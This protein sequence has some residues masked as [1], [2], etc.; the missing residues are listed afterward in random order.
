MPTRTTITSRSF[1]QCRTPGCTRPAR[2]NIAYLCGACRERMRDNGDA[3][4]TTIRRTELRPM[5]DRV[6]E[7][8]R[9]GHLPMICRGLQ[10]IN[11][12]LVRNSEGTLAM[13]DRGRAMNRHTV[14]AATEMLKVA[15]NVDPLESGITIA[16][17]Y[18]LAERTPR[19]I[20]S[21]EGMAGQLTR[22]YRAQ[23]GIAMGTTWDDKRQRTAL[24]YRPLPKDSTAL[25]ATT[26]REA[27]VSWLVHVMAADKKER[28]AQKQA[29]RELA[30]GFEGV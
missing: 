12:A 19:R 20:V 7:I 26:L 5:E 4:Q 18:L 3:L 24:W 11:D 27:Y 28:E 29:A 22:V 17:L 1:H 25:I 10:T 15:K 14:I 30:Q 6:R 13:R 2:S 8:I 16:A 21:D 9:R 23:Q